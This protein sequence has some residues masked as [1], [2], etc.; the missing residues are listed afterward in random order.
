MHS[1]WNGHE[2]RRSQSLENVRAHLRELQVACEANHREPQPEP[3]EAKPGAGVHAEIDMSDP[4]YAPNRPPPPRREPRPGEPLWTLGK[5]SRR[6]ACQLFDHGAQGAEYRLL[7]NGEF[8]VRRRFGGLDLAVVGA[9]DMR[10]QLEHEGWT[11]RSPLV[12]LH[13][14]HRRE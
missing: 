14:G 1:R 13:Y 9:E 3:D 10:C 11:G 4:V 5:G 6:L 7:V 12:L 8:C 2:R